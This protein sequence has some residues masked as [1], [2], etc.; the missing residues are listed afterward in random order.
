MICDLDKYERKALYV[1]GWRA[2]IRGM[3]FQEVPSLQ[4]LMAQYG[5][6]VA[7]YRKGSK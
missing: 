5:V 6:L 2:F 4:E 7:K 3:T 1:M